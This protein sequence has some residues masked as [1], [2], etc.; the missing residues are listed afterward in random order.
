MAAAVCYC[1]AMA[2]A[3]RGPLVVLAVTTAAALGGCNRD[4]DKDAALRALADHDV[5][6]AQLTKVS[7]GHYSFAG[8]G[9]SGEACKGTVKRD[10]APDAPMP[11]Q[12]EREC[13]RLEKRDA[14][15][16]EAE[17]KACNAG[18]GGPACTH[19]G[20]YLMDVVGTE[21]AELEARGLLAKECERGD[22]VACG[23]YSLLQFGA[24]GGPKDR[25]GA[26]VS[27]TRACELGHLIRCASAGAMWMSGEGGPAD[28]AR[29]RALFA[30]GCSARDDSACYFHG[31]ALHRGDGGPKDDAGCTRSMTRACK[32]G[33]NLACEFAKDPSLMDKPPPEPTGVADPGPAFRGPP[34][35]AP[36][37]PA[38]A[39]P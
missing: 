31:M 39:V 18:K 5:P 4:K 14:A 28:L 23:R 1:D 6:S 7:D 32:A 16:L 29:G 15:W 13:D 34:L 11:W 19:V 17:R 20:A 26:R 8:L 38:P 27:D 24:R 25:A 12:V 9:G 3:L 30:L 21:G 2:R 37:P 36:A 33:F 10:S 35:P 22:G